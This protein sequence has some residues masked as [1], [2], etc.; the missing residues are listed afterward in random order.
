MYT[1]YSTHWVFSWKQQNYNI[2]YNIRWETNDYC[3]RCFYPIEQKNNI[4]PTVLYIQLYQNKN[5][6]FHVDVLF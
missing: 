6:M 4:L 3:A 5:K 2:N 1:L